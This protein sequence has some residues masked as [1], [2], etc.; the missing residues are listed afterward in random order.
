MKEAI[1]KLESKGYCIDNHF[2]QFDASYISNFSYDI[3][4]IYHCMYNLLKERSGYCGFKRMRCL[5]KD[6]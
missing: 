6:F 1:K 5:W 2:C 4:R 3:D